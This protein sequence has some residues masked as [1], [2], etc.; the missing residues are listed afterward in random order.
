MDIQF[1]NIEIP[2]N[3]YRGPSPSKETII[4]RDALRRL[5][6]GGPALVVT[7]DPTNKR[8]TMRTVKGLANTLTSIAATIEKGAFTVRKLDDGRVGVWRKK[9]TSQPLTIAA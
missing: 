4:F 8:K 9:D 2:T 7:P 5:S 6:V 1:A 3:G